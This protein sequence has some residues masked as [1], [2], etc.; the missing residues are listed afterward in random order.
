[1]NVINKGKPSLMNLKELMQAFIDHRIEI[2]TRR[3]NFDL[4]KAKKRAHIVEGLIKAVQGIDTVIEII[5]NSLNPQDALKNLQD[6]IG[7]SEE[8]AKAIADMKLIS[9]SRLETDNLVKELNDLYAQI[10]NAS[11]VLQ[12]KEKL[13][14]II[15]EELDEVA[16][17]IWG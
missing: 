10:K 2:V 8:Q 9:L 17:K 5:R 11:D 12:D 14:N 4:E 1:M 13:M 15:K 3:T 7:V 16:K 6:T